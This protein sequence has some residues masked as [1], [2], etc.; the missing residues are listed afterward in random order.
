M[1]TTVD[2]PDETYRRL[3]ITAAEKN[4]TVRQVV[5]E[6]LDLVLLQQNSA[7]PAKRLKLPLIRSTRKDKL[8]IDNE[9]IY[10]IIDFP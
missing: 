6:G 7:P 8:V 3:K 1:R 10:E 9:K 4:S 2:I 5:L